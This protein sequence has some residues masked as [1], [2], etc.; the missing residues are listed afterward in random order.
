MKP[1]SINEIIRQSWQSFVT[2]WGVMLGA[3][4]VMLVLNIAFSFA[5][6]Q[7]GEKSI[8]AVVITLFS[9]AVSIVVQLGLYRM[10]L[11]MV[12][13][14]EARIEQMFTE[15][16]AA[17]RYIG[18]TIIYMV[19]VAIGFILLI[20]P[21]VIFAIKYG[22]YGYAIVDRNLGVRDSLKLSAKITE[23]AKWQ[24]LGLWVLMVCLIIISIIPLGLGLIVTVPMAMVLSAIVYNTLL[25]HSEQASISP[26][27]PSNTPA[28]DA[29]APFVPL[30]E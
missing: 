12:R 29:P 26:E 23:G 22:Y 30:G 14:K 21:G 20:V 10:W 18:A 5:T 3:I 17:F 4:G 7:V 15:Y 16:Q 6:E 27:V 11:D 8:G 25:V 28:S 19:I 24:I 1:F 9:I 2:H 13:G